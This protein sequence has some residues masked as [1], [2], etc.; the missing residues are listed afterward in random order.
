MRVPL[1]SNPNYLP[2]GHLQVPSGDW[3]LG[4][5]GL[6]LQHMNSQGSTNIQSTTVCKMENQE[7]EKMQYRR[8]CG[9]GTHSPVG[10][11]Q[12]WNQPWWERAGGRELSVN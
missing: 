12:K 10:T 6:G 11:Q 2:K 7:K 9:L 5:Q 3:V 1:S 8:Y 4:H